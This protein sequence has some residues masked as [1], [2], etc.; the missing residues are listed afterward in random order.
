MRGFDGFIR[1][2]GLRDHLLSNALFTWTVNWGRDMSSRLHR[3][4]VTPK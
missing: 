4:L 1:D 3:F 2:F